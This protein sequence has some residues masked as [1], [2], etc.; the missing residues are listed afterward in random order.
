MGIGRGLGDM[1]CEFN[2]L[3]CGRLNDVEVVSCRVCGAPRGSIGGLRFG[4]HLILSHSRK[5]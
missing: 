4:D 1:R 2:N 5:S 3:H